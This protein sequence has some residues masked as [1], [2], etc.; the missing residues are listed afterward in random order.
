MTERDIVERCRTNADVLRRL[1]ENDAEQTG[2]LVI[3]KD[4]ETAAEEITSFRQMITWRPIEE[5]EKSAT[6]WVKGHL[7]Y[8]LGFCPDGDWD[9]DDCIHI[10]WWDPDRGWVSDADV[11]VKPTM[12]CHR[13]PPPKETP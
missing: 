2:K 3:A 13:P 8:Y 5:A 7:K 12:F 4:F 11:P 6:P 10:I 9:H 1:Y